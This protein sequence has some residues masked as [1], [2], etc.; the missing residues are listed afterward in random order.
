MTSRLGR[1]ARD[2]ATK[3]K[4]QDMLARDR[5][6]RLDRA[7]RD[8]ATRTSRLDRATRTSR[9]DWAARDS[10]KDKQAGHWAGQPEPVQ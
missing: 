3:T 6:S 10:N 4:R 2:R 7:A 1:E 9:L 8:R 5:A